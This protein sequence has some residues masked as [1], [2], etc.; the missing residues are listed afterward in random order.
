MSAELYEHQGVSYTLTELCRISHLHR[1]T[2]RRRLNLGLPL[3]QVIGFSG[4][5]HLPRLDVS[6]IGKKVPVVFHNSVPVY[7]WMQPTLER[8][9]VATICGSNRNSKLT[10]VFY[11]IELENGKKLVTYPGEFEF[12]EGQPE[13]S[14]EIKKND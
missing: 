5:Q 12:I 13:A 6:D 11:I 8:Q 9:Y 3:E 1:D 7:E 2:I 14:Q 10:K 4:S